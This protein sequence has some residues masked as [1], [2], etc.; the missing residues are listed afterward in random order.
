MTYTFRTI[1]EPDEGGT[2]HAYAPTLSGCH[3]WGDSL[4]SAK[5]NLKDAIS[6]YIA[7]LLDDGLTV[8]QD[9]SFES[10]TT[11]TTREL[12]PFMTQLQAYA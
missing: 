1:I 11:V 4:Q 6:V 5:D 10:F 3:T 2:Y 8:P 12:S 7:S 9:N